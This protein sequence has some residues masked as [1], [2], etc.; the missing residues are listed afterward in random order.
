MLNVSWGN[1]LRFVGLPYDKTK[2]LYI[3]CV[4]QRHLARNGKLG[5]DF[6]FDLGVCP[7][8]TNRRLRFKMKCS[9]SMSFRPQAEICRARLNENK[10]DFSLWSK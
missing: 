3:W 7:Q 5:A 10:A 6:W 9:P 8:N 1:T 4:F 2:E